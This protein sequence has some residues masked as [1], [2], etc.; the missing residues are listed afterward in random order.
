MGPDRCSVAPFGERR[1]GEIADCALLGSKLWGGQP[2]WPDDDIPRFDAHRCKS[3]REHPGVAGETALDVGL[4]GG[5]HDEQHADAAV[6][7]AGE[8]AGAAAMPSGGGTSV[9]PGL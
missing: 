1:P 8:L 6:F 3:L 2:L 9:N 5:S 4:A 7:A